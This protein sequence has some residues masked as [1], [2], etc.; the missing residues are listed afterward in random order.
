MS[1]EQLLRSEQDGVLELVLNRP[2][3]GNAITAEIL[4]GLLDGANELATR[5]DLRVLLIRSTGRFFSAGADVA[6]LKADDAEG[7]PARFRRI[8][9]SGPFS[10]QRVGDAFE[11]VE[12]PVVVA[13]HAA[14]FGGALELSLS[15]DFR[16]A[17]VEATYSL[18]EVAMGLLPGSG[19]TSRLTRLVGSHWARWLVMAGETIDAQQALG[20]GLVHAVYPKDTLEEEARR[21][22]RRLASR[23]PEALAAAKLA[24]ELSVDLDRA[25]ARNIERIANSYL[26][27]GAEHQDKMAQLRAQLERPAKDGSKQS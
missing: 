25:Q 5:S 13:H 4:R 16:L 6:S 9:S 7:S 24:V 17:A 26:F 22:C 2:Q 10:F 11:A 18:P 19:G 15:C 14:C 23:P 21:F 1:D 20:M 3:K 8:Y 12:K 27:F